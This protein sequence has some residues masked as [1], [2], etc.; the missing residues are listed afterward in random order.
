MI[1]QAK[2]YKHTHAIAQKPAFNRPPPQ[3]FGSGDSAV[4]AASSVVLGAN[5]LTPPGED[6][7]PA[8]VGSRSKGKEDLREGEPRTES[9]ALVIFVRCCHV[10]AKAHPTSNDKTGAY[11]RL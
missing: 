11:F 4:S 10:L 2:R 6:K 5:D 8:F 7:P 9:D 1:P 3:R